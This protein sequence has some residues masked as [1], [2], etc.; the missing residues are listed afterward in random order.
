MLLRIVKLLQVSEILQ[1]EKWNMVRHELKKIVRKKL[2]DDEG[3]MSGNVV[4]EADDSRRI[5]K[6][7]VRIPPPPIAQLVKERKSRFEDPDKTLDYSW[8]S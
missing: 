8:D 1:Q 5:S 6:T 3:G 4:L 2:D 7:L